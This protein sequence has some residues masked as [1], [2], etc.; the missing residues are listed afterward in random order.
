MWLDWKDWILGESEMDII[1]INVGTTLAVA[2]RVG[3]NLC[4]HPIGQTHRSAP[5]KLEIIY[6][7][8]IC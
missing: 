4:V 1:N 7:R 6:R 3:V 5:T 8:T 2:R